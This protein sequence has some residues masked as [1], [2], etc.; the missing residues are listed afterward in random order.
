M[1]GVT[2]N[3]AV[4]EEMQFIATRGKMPGAWILERKG[5][6]LTNHNSDRDGAW[7][8]DLHRLVLRIHIYIFAVV[9]YLLWYVR[10]ACSISRAFPARVIYY[11]ALLVVYAVVQRDKYLSLTKSDISIMRAE[12]DLCGPFRIHASSICDKCDTALH[13]MVQWKS[14]V[15]QADK[16]QTKTQWHSKNADAWQ[17]NSV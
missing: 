4:R 3:P 2:E 12:G 10:L 11:L 14:R 16:K 7:G 6:I 17:Q 9:L 5:F 15:F 8:Y 1:R 13:S